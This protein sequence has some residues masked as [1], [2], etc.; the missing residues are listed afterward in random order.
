M[1]WFDKYAPQSTKEVVGQSTMALSKH[2]QRN[3]KSKA[4]LIH[5]PAGTG[6]TS[7][8][9]ALAREAGYELVEVDASSVRNAESVKKIVGN[10]SLTMS[11]FGKRV[12]LID[13]VDSLSDRGGI[14]ELIKCIKATRTPIYLTAIDP[15]DK[16]IRTLRGYCELVEFKKVRTTSIKALL[17]KICDNEGVKAEDPVLYSIALHA[18]GDVRAAINNL[19]MLSGDGEVTEYELD[20]M[21][22]REKPVSVFNALQTLFKT[23]RFHEAI[24]ALDDVGLDFNTRLLWITENVPNEYSLQSELASA[25]NAL[26]R[27]DVFNGRIRRRQYWRFLVYVNALMTAGVNIAREKD[28]GF[29]KYKNPTKILKLWKSKS[30]RELRKQLA[31]KLKPSF[32]ASLKKTLQALPFIKALARNEEFIKAYELTSDEVEVLIK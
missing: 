27:A 28:S 4:I 23:T 30:K 6:K 18:K 13:D 31:T 25:F 8:V 14:T 19:E 21:G 24:H 5:G 10:A 26:S 29:V 22:Y 11:L 20:A 1:V 16:K 7:S 2:A 32:N 12:I 15:W 9:H 17:R 3:P